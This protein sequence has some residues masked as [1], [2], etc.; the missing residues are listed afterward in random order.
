M[1]VDEDIGINRDHPQSRFTELAHA[2]FLLLRL[3]LEF[4]EK[5]GEKRITIYVDGEVYPEVLHRRPGGL[6]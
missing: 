2:F 1:G 5:R 4:G 6:K 3:C